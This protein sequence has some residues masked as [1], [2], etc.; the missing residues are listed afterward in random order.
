MASPRHST[1][2]LLRVLPNHHMHPR[3]IQF[4]LIKCITCLPNGRYIDLSVNGSFADGMSSRAAKW[5]E[6]CCGDVMTGLDTHVQDISDGLSFLFNSVDGD[7]PA[8]YANVRSWLIQVDQF[9]V[10]IDVYSPY[11]CNKCHSIRSVITN[12]SCLTTIHRV[13]NCNVINM[14]DFSGFCIIRHLLLGVLRYDEVHN[15]DCRASSTTASEVINA[16]IIYL[17]SCRDRD[18]KYSGFDTDLSSDFDDTHISRQ[19]VERCDKHLSN[20]HAI[21]DH[22]PITHSAFVDKSFDDAQSCV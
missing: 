12:P 7:I 13:C 3:Q 19:V 16:N 15:I 10:G 18:A 17:K 6:C 8:Y 22:L 20:G 11:Y 14:P 5:R 2:H 1:S 9:S 21:V 4:E